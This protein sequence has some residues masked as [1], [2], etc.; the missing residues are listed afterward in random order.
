MVVVLV[1]NKTIPTESV[2]VPRP[3]NRAVPFAGWCNSLSGWLGFRA[4][5]VF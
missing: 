5:D 4:M 2:N 1:I 3:N